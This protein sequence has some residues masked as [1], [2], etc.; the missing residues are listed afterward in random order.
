MPRTPPSSVRPGAL[1]EAAL[2]A[3][4]ATR[5]AFTDCYVVDVAGPVTQPQFVEAFYTTAVFR[6]E[7]RLLAWTMSKPSTDD[8][9]RR[10]ATGRCDTFA[11]WRVEARHDDQLLMCDVTGRTRSWLM[12]EP[13]ADGS[14]TRL[15]FGSA[16]VP[17]RDPRTGS[18][19]MG[20]AFHALL[21]FHAI[22]SRV[23]LGAAR[24]RLGAL[25]RGSPLPRTRPE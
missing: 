23:L 25:G 22:Y 4:Y 3:A 9:A 16:V 12:T 2:L 24:A 11:A 17:A 18:A 7:R 8:D 1:P 5:D 19:T 14:G 15:Y 10:L 21:G 13:L 20:R 6:I